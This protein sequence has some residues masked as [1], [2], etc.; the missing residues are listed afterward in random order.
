MGLFRNNQKAD[1]ALTE[2][3]LA[4]ISA[5]LIDGKND[6]FTHTVTGSLLATANA[7]GLAYDCGQPGE[8]PPP[9]HTYPRR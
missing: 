5:D 3:M 2:R 6:D 9:G 4:D 7:E 8:Y 1:R